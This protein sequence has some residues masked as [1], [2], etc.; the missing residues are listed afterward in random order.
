MS[1]GA[2]MKQQRG[3]ALI[4]TVVLLMVAAIIG[5]YAMRSAIT[6]DKASA[7]IYNKTIT[8]NAAEHGVSKFYEWANSQ[9]T[10]SKGWILTPADRDAWHP[11]LPNSGPGSANV[12]DNGYFWIDTNEDVDGCPTDNT[13]PCWD[14]SKAK[15]EVTAVVTGNLV[16]GTTVLGTSKIRVK[17]GPEGGNR[18]PDVPAALTLGGG[19]KDYDGAAAPKFKVE[20]GIKDAVATAEE[21]DADIVVDGVDGHSKGTNQ[22]DQYTCGT[23]T[24]E[25]CINAQNLGIWNNPTE[26]IAFLNSISSDPN[27]IVINRHATSADLEIS[28]CSGIVI[29]R[30]DL[31][32]N[33]NPF[34]TCPDKTFNGVILV[35]GGDL[36]I[37]GGGG[38]IIN[39]AV[40]VAPLYIHDSAGNP[41]FSP[42]SPAA[43]GGITATDV[44]INGAHMTIKYNPAPFGSLEDIKKGKYATK[45]KILEW[46]DVL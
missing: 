6:Q 12:G 8:T 14:D 2:N 13:N 35:L 34:N 20:G 21:T 22:L 46:T 24:G 25:A 11:T 30:G 40:Y 45:A 26:L 5:L 17:L 41:V 37:N 29:I 42:N 4:V 3:F 19:V 10:T 1:N 33:G 9:I 39:G 44:D 43:G 18:L 16:Q 31:T 28:S 38:G 7:N 15:Y 36:F 32:I 23:L 27:V